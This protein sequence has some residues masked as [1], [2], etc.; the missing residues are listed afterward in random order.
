M[1]FLKQGGVLVRNTYDFDCQNQTCF[2]NLI[3]DSFGGLEELSSNT[4]KKVKRSLEHFEFKLVDAQLTKD[5]G[6]PILKATYDDYA[7]MDYAMN[8][9]VFNEMM[10][11]FESSQYDYWGAFDRDNGDLVG[12]CVNR[13]WKEACGYE[14]I[15][16]I[17]KYKRKSTS[18]PYYG[19]Y[20]SMNQYYLQ[21]K[22]LRYVTS[23]TRSITEHSNIQ[24]FLEEKF[25]FRKSY[26]RLAVHYKWWMKIAVNM[27]YPFRKTISLRR[28]KAILNLEAMQ[29]GEK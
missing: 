20:Y 28:V 7:V 6:Y 5:L 14:T 13:I 25:H 19:F 10:A 15:A 23:G 11:L 9:D 26:C 3:K 29:R 17:P 1:S 16:F 18:Y 4:R 2:W 22:G 24:P 12:F 27:L 8:P 21:E